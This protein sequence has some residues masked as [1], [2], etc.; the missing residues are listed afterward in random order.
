MRVVSEDQ[1]KEAVN[2]LASGGVIVF[3]TETSYGLGCDA[4]NAAAVARIFAIK[5]REAG[6]GLPVL[7]SGIDE[8]KKMVIFSR[9]AEELAR[10]FWPGALNVVAPLIAG[11]SLAPGC[12]ENN[13]QSVRVSSH[14]TAQK[15]VSELGRPV[16]ATSANISG[17][18]ALYS[19]EHVEEMFVQASDH[20]DLALD[21]G[22]LPCVLASTSVRM[23]GD[24]VV[25]LREGSIK[26]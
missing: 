8:A 12:S 7:V 22:E 17:A 6:K 26:I 21:A 20:P 13:S 10:K 15:I 24:D 23:V 3:P 14:P 16:V 18:N 19:L 4:T 2:V 5:G 11:F 25:V 1:W 9:A